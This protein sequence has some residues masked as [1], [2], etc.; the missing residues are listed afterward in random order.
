VDWEGCI[1]VDWRRR[2]C[3]CCPADTEEV[4]SNMDVG[5]ILLRRK[6]EKKRR[7]RELDR[8]RGHRWGQE[9]VGPKVDC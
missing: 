7:G 5:L 6:R 9:T 2:G 1:P 3:S 8:W 4:V